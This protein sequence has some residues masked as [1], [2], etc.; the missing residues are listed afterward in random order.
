MVARCI[1]PS[2]NAGGLGL[3]DDTPF[4]IAKLPSYASPRDKINLSILG[5][6]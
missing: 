6:K 3:R 4:N 1:A 5:K 2:I